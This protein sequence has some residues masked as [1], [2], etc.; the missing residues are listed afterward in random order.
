MTLTDGNP[1]QRYSMALPMVGVA[2]N[3][4][5]MA[6]YAGQG[7]ER[8]KDVLP[9]AMIVETTVREACACLSKFA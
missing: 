9:A 1:V 4:E 5:A 2:G 6:Q 8:I 7:V 3:V